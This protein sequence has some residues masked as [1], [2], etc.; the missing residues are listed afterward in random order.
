MLVRR[1]QKKV[2]PGIKI[3]SKVNSTIVTAAEDEVVTA[4]DEMSM[5]DR[6]GILVDN[7]QNTR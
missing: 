4:E 3:M 2:G 6:D 7:L 5:S 1:S